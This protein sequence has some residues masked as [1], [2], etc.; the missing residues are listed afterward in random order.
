[1]L[2]T[3]LLGIVVDF[4]TGAIYKS[5][6]SKTEIEQ[7]LQKY[8]RQGKPC[9]RLRDDGLYKIELIDGQLKES[10]IEQSAIPP[11]VWQT[12]EKEKSSRMVLVPQYDR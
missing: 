6:G 10:K 3:G 4:A 7:D 5:S 8:A 2:F 11:V 1:V 12:I 9:Y